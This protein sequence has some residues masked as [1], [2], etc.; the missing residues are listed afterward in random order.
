M[1]EVKTGLLAKKFPTIPTDVKLPSLVEWKNTDRFY[2]KDRESLSIPKHKSESLLLKAERILSGQL[3]YFSAEWRDLGKDWSWHLN[4]TTGFEY[5]RLQH[6][7]CINE[8]NLQSGDIKYVWEAS[9]FCFLYD[10]VRYDYH[11]NEDHSE[12][13]IGKI[14]D[15]IEK[16]PLNCGPNYKCS[17]EISLRV[18]NWL[19][20]L[21]FYKNSDTLTDER[22]N[23][24]IRSIYWQIRHV[25]SNIN[26]SRYVVRNNHAITETMTVYL[27][28][29]MFPIL[30]D[31]K[32][33][34]KKGKR[35]FEQEIDYQIAEDGS[36]IQNSMNYHRVLIQL[37]T[38]AIAI[39][40]KNGDKFK[41]KTYEKAHKALNFLYQCQDEVSGWLPNYGFNDGALFF[42][43]SDYDYRNYQPQLD[44]L[45]YLL[46]GKTL[47]G[48]LME[49]SYWVTASIRPTLNM[50][51][52]VR[53]NG[54]TAFE[55]SGYYVIREDLTL[56][57]IRC[58]RWNGKGDCTD[59]LHLDVWYKGENV[60]IDGGSFRYN[61]TPKLIRYFGGTE[62][63][64]TVMIGAN[65]QMER[66]PRF[67]WM[68]PPT[69]NIAKISES[70]SQY[71]FE[72]EIEA[73]KHVRKGIRH[74]RTITKDK[75]HAVWFVEDVVYN[76]EGYTVSQLWHTASNH[77]AF[78]NEEANKV[79]KGT[80]YSSYYGILEPCKQIEFSS[81]KMIKTKIT[82]Q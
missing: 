57:F 67:I 70:P 38:I 32:K 47:Y 63:H 82:I 3:R 66:G 14:L 69:I 53:N 39:S 15:W 40:E 9:R 34:R 51:A 80:V 76:A 58:G 31:S 62:S 59:E 28:G 54:I 24:I 18:L 73:F 11:Y 20:A 74:K 30:S 36:F 17:Q 45:H 27:M 10:I 12:F 68:Y 37:L 29:L 1:A 56:S 81:N 13:V 60:L 75:K 50:Q 42:P 35:W 21:N 61:T 55:T 77:I 19:F 49:D 64:N 43:L 41:V 16:N 26:F 25:Y 44:A 5:D 4:Y 46:V 79:S 8:L 52:L 2:F 71:I 65:D 33:W 72:G 48:S 23:V 78:E 22:W 6:W 7:T